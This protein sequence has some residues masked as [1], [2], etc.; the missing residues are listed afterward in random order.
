MPELAQ[1]LH[2]HQHAL[3]TRV[4]TPVRLTT[5]SLLIMPNV[6]LQKALAAAS[7][8]P[9]ASGMMRV[10]SQRHETVHAAR[11]EYAWLSVEALAT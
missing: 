7:A 3:L 2:R 11:L 10:S 1:R 5:C 8:S 4:R 9:L 6:P